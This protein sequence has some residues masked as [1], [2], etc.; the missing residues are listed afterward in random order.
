MNIEYLKFSDE[1]RK[2]YCILTTIE[3]DNGEKKVVK[4]ALFPEGKE[5][6]ENI[7]RYSKALKLYYP[8]VKICPV[9]MKN[10][11]LYFDFID[12]RMLS[13]LYAEAIE[14]N[15]K[16]KVIKLLKL[17][18]SI[19]VGNEENN[20]IFKESELSRKWFGNL[21]V[22]EGKSALAYSN[23]DAIAGN[24]FIQNEVPVFIDYEWVFEFPVPTDIVIYHCILDAYLHNSKFSEIIS[25][26]E[27]MDVLGI[28]CDI[29]KMEMA[30]KTFF[31]NVIEEDDGKSFALM[32]NLC[33]K[34]IINEDTEKETSA[35]KFEEENML[36][37]HE[38]SRLNEEKDKIGKYWKQSI[39]INRLYEKKNTV[40]NDIISK[41]TSVE[42]IDK[43]IYDKDVHIKNC[44]NII[45]ELRQNKSLLKRMIR[46]IRKRLQK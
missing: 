22:F 2:K 4:E 7:L 3:S 43:I 38:I 37:K 34:K 6:L 29:D 12:G 45:N 15:D 35:I 10:D 16:D 18:K 31:K 24:I 25:I 23:F 30:Y 1:R 19:I 26:R 32:K 11:K 42:T 14:K 39:E 17:H 13:E 8:K 44:E 27:A 28:V 20:I 33:L 9:E 41:Y 46:K 40:L 5:H 21:S 36:L